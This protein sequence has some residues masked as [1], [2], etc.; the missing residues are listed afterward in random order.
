MKFVKNPIKDI[1]DSGFDKFLHR[2]GI[3]NE[4]F[5]TQ[6][7]NAAD[8]TYIK[9]LLASVSL[10]GVNSVNGLTGDVVLTTTN[11]AEGTNLY[12]TDERAMDAVFPAFQD[13]A[14]IDVTAD[15][16]ADTITIDLKTSYTDSI[17]LRQDGG[18]MSGKLTI[19]VPTTTTEALILQTTDDNTTKNIFEFQDSLGSQLLLITADGKLVG[20]TATT[21][22]L[23]LQTTTGVGTTGADMHFL[24]GSNGGTEAMTI[25]NSGFVGIGI[26]APLTG[27][28]VQDAGS[29]TVGSGVFKISR[30][31]SA[32]M[33]FSFRIDASN[34]YM[35]LDTRSG[36]T[37][38]NVLT[39]TRSSSPNIGF[40]VTNPTS[41]FTMAGTNSFSSGN[42]IT[43][44]NLISHIITLTGAAST[45]YTPFYTMVVDRMYLAGT[46][47]NQTV[48]D[49]AAISIIGAPIGSTNTTITRSYGLWIKGAAVGT[50][51]TSYGSYI[52]AP[53]GGSANYAGAFTGGNL[54][55]GTATPGAELHVLS[56]AAGT[57]GLLVQG[58]SSQSANLVSVRD[59]SNN[60]LISFDPNG[61]AIFNEQGSASADIRIEGDTITDLFFVDASTDQVQLNGGQIVNITTVNAATYDL[62]TTDFIVHVTYTSTASVTSLT[63]PSAQTVAGRVFVVKDA[64]FN[65]SIK[66]ITIDTEGS[67]TIDGSTTYVISSDGAS[68]SLYSDGSNWFIY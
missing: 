22:D 50:V 3:D 5:D 57:I 10:F 54:G 27:L 66:S 20:G 62:L 46:N 26:T 6:R 56:E 7:L 38:Y 17:Y 36:G 11:I 29:N 67:E 13:S 60:V 41:K 61:G 32:D 35:H 55:I 65:S 8:K 33:A 52:E 30:S 18:T 48:T 49:A 47:A 53:T 28:H 44:I 14:S 25:L 12:F 43:N 19:A 23:T 1:A 9:K 24:V 45:V 31:A 59:N 68:V 40:N 15:D 34:G 21:S 63:L 42:R 37:N 51:T 64:G 4:G 2:K 16:G 39:V 58:A